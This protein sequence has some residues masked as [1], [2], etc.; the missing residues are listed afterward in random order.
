MSDC[1]ISKFWFSDGT[2]L[3]TMTC[4]YTFRLMECRD[5]TIVKF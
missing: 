3:F 5:M 4:T 1:D 2:H